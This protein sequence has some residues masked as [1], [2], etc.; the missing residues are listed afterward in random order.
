MV[1][2]F[3]FELSKHGRVCFPRAAPLG[4]SYFLPIMIRQLPDSVAS[5]VFFSVAAPYPHRRL[6]LHP[7]LLYYL[8]SWA[9]FLPPFFASCFFA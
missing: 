5:D 2:V 6:L 8:F 7:P 1:E 4:A 3:R 9:V